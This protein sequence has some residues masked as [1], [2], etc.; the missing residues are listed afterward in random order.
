MRLRLRLRERDRICGSLATQIAEAF[1]IP[2]QSGRDAFHGVLSAAAAAEARRIGVRVKDPLV[3]FLEQSERE[4][5][6]SNASSAAAATPQQQRRGSRNGFNSCA[7]SASSD[8]YQSKQISLPSP[9][10]FFCETVSSRLLRWRETLAERQGGCW[11]SGASVCFYCLGVAGFL[12]GFK[13]YRTLC[14][15]NFRLLL[16]YRIG[17]EEFARVWGADERILLKGALVAGVGGKESGEAVMKCK[18]L[19]LR[20]VP[21]VAAS[22]RDV[23]R[24]D[25]EREEPTRFGAVSILPPTALQERLCD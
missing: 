5:A 22:S 1:A 11:G 24:E 3:A 2:P 10:A 16:Q 20:R 21:Q 4:A 19:N 25:S 7:D 15:P 17:C 14:A 12:Q 6:S 18:V 23:R 13:P 9:R 8:N